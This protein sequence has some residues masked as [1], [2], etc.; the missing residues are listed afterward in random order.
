MLRICAAIVLLL[1]LVGC[2]QGTARPGSNPGPPHAL[3]S[4]GK[5]PQRMLQGSSC[6][7]SNGSGRCVDAAGMPAILPLIPRLVVAR[8]S[9]GFIRLGFDPTH[10][11]LEIDGRPVPVAAGRLVTFTPT[12]A[13]VVNLWLDAPQGSVEYFAQLS[14]GRG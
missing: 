6:W 3:I 13:G 4:F 7:Q 8:G 9:E 12:R 5:P 1:A 14:F 11:H 2:G 10:A